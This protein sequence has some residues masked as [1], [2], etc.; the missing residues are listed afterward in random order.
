M[1]ASQAQAT[2]QSN[3]H[4]PPTSHTGHTSVWSQQLGHF[5]K[6][7]SFSFLSQNVCLY[8]Q[9]EELLCSCLCLS[10]VYLTL[11]TPSPAPTLCVISPSGC[12][13]PPAVG[14]AL[15]TSPMTSLRQALC[16]H[17]TAARVPSRDLH[18]TAP[19]LPVRRLTVPHQELSSGQMWALIFLHHQ[20]FWSHMP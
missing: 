17:I 2:T 1:L 7:F 20:A 15:S 16:L 10:T 19:C 18:L 5:R 9:T 12:P 3:L 11:W 4:I 8:S 6:P 13:S 14:A